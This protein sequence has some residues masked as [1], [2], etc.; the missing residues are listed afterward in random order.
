MQSEICATVRKKKNLELCARWSYV[1]PWEKNPKLCASYVHQTW[2]L[3]PSQDSLKQSEDMCN[4]E[5][6]TIS[7]Y[8]QSEAICRPC[9]PNLILKSLTRISHNIS[10]HKLQRILWKWTNRANGAHNS[11]SQL[12]NAECG[13]EHHYLVAELIGR[14]NYWLK[15]RWG[16][17]FFL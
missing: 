2:F 5:K 13:I 12:Q 14:R 16:R 7:S 17:W 6:K 10:N 11:H 8:V 3:N 9:P 4:S 1:Q 15:G